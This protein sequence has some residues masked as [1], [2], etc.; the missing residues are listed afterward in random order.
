MGHRSRRGRGGRSRSSGDPRIGSF[1]EATKVAR[2]YCPK[3]E[4]PA[5]GI[6]AYLSAAGR[7]RDPLLDRALSS[8]SGA[9]AP[10]F[11]EETTRPFFWFFASTEVTPADRCPCQV[12]MDGKTYRVWAV[13]LPR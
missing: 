10:V 13:S 7:E 12:W 9:M 11:A 5:R 8:T 4:F 2:E 3:R 6:V 1:D